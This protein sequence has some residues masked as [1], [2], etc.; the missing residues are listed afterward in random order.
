MLVI[1]T[2]EQLLPPQ[3]V[4]Q[5]CLWADHQG[6]PRWQQGKLRCGQVL[7]RTTDEQP[8]QY[9]CQMGFRVANVE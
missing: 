6:Q 8:Q 7:A 1:V 4:C 3:C 9:Q 2:E 5:T